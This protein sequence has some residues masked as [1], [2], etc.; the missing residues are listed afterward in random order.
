MGYP[1]YICGGKW[2]ETKRKYIHQVYRSEPKSI[3]SHVLRLT[4]QEDILLNTKYFNYVLSNVAP[5]SS[6]CSGQKFCTYTNSFTSKFCDTYFQITCWI[7]FSH[8]HLPIS[9]PIPIHFH[10]LPRLLQVNLIPKYSLCSHSYTQQSVLS[11]LARKVL[12]N[13]Q[14]IALSAHHFNSFS[15]H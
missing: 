9:Y 10:L 12:L 6:N 4:K 15:S 8:L 7:H 13:I 3:N 1:R 2:E 11:W 14:K 5:W